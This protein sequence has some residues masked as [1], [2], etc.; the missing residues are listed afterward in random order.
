MAGSQLDC[1]QS[2]SFARKSV[3]RNAKQNAAH[4]RAVCRGRVSLSDT[5]SGESQVALATQSLHVTPAVTLGRLLV[6]RFPH[7]FSSKTET[8]QCFVDPLV[9][10]SQLNA[11][12]YPSCMAFLS[13]FHYYGWFAVSRHQK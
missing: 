8:A 6:L 4:K 11:Q 10:I 7:G 5:R 9:C 3:E 13:I 12:E 2:L 1:E